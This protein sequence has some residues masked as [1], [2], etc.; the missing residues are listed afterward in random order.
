M[1]LWA[2][3]QLALEDGEDSSRGAFCSGQGRENTPSA[4]AIPGDVDAD[5]HDVDCAFWVGGREG[6]AGADGEVVEMQGY[7]DQPGAAIVVECEQPASQRRD[8]AIGRSCFAAGSPGVDISLCCAPSFKRGRLSED[9]V[10][11]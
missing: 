5:V 10:R 9:D 2:G 7:F 4:V 11:Q 6:L 1:Q 8:K 3:A